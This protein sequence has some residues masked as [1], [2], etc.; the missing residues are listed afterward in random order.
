RKHGIETLGF[1]MIG[2][3]PETIEEINMT[4]RFACETDLDEALYSI[5]IPYAGTE[6]ARQV[7]RERLYD[8]DEEE[9]HLNHVHRIKPEEFDLRSLKRRQRRA[10]LLCLL[11]RFRLIRM[12]PRL[13]SDRSS[14]K[15][16]RATDRNFLP[17]FLPRQ[18][19]RIN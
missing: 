3:P 12:L 9:E 14:K 5:V 4:I 7:K 11:S 16:L 6:L 10:Y 17:E 19:S 15:Y 13:M 1:F 18:T 8:P 2:F